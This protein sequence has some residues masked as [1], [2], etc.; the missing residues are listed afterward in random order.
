[1]LKLFDNLPKCNSD[2][3]GNHCWERIGIW[4]NEYI[5]YKCSQCRKCV[6]EDIV[7]LKKLGNQAPKNKESEATDK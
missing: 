5:V 2:Y 6:Y 7:P 1:M 4:R 3:R